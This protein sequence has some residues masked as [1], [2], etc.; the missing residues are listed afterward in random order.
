MLIVYAHPNKKGN[1]GEVLCRS[2]EFLDKKGIEYE[3]LDLYE[4]NYNPVMNQNEHY[5]SGGKEISLENQR[6]QK[7]FKKHKRFVFI[8]PTWW[9]NTPAILKGFLDKVFTNHFA[10][11][12]RNKIPVGL[13]NG[14][15]VVITTTG[16]PRPFGRIILKD[17]SITVVTKDTLKFCG[18]KSRGFI[19][20]SCV[21]FNETSKGKIKKTVKKALNY[22]I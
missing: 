9:N 7:M 5:T 2:C 22:L 19:I 14:K 17:R 12:Y 20:G 16:A 6:I 1:C 13:L 21:N 4:M 18:I 11:E 15:A 10:F 8:Y 3:I